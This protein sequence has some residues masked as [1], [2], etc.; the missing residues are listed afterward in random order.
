MKYFMVAFIVILSAFIVEKNLA[1][2][3]EESTKFCLMD[4]IQIILDSPEFVALR[5]D[6][7]L[8][9]LIMIYSILQSRVKMSMSFP[10]K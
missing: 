1:K 5:A 3:N 2:E 4:L 10:P 6:E 7:Q 9:V 8:R